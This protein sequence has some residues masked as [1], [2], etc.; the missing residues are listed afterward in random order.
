MGRIWDWL[1][2]LSGRPALV[3]GDPERPYLRRWRLLPKNHWCNVYLHQFLRDDEDRALHDHPFE[4]LSLLFRGEYLEETHGPEGPAG[5][6]RTQH[7]RAPTLIRRSA[8]YTHRILLVNERPAW[9]LFLRGRAVRRWGFHCKHGWVWWRNFG[10]PHEPASRHRG[11]G[12]DADEHL[13]AY[14]P[15]GQP[16]SR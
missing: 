10:E 6:R 15:D 5:P 14:G 4:S 12:A 11:C 2:Q 7:F 9:T 8:T 16:V 3:V 13:P 1:Q